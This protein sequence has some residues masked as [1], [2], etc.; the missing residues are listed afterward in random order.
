MKLLDQVE[1]GLLAGF[2]GLAELGDN[3]VNGELGR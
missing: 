1:E 2:R 3:L